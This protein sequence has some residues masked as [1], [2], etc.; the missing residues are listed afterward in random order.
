M[1][2]AYRTLLEHL[3][4][5]RGGEFARLDA[6]RV[7]IVSGPAR[8]EARATIRGFASSAT[9][10]FRKP[11]VRRSGVGIDYEICLRPLFFRHCTAQ[12]RLLILIHELWHA[13]PA[14]DGTLNPE[15]RHDQ[16]SQRDIDRSV[17]K[18]AEPWLERDRADELEFLQY[19]GELRMESWLV[20]PPSHVPSD[21][22]R[23]RTEY[24]ERLLF[25]AIIEQRNQRA[26]A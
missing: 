8:R 14:F 20:R 13:A 22:D 15:H 18:I 21:N 23:E 9:H 10:P 12:Q 11:T 7:L 5:S 24:D 26:P 25:S 17:R 6:T 3:Q 19:E 4:A 1:D 2:E 16:R